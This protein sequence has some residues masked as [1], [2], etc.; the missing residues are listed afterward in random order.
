MIMWRIVRFMALSLVLEF[1][2]P[3][4]I[5]PRIFGV[6]QTT[7]GP[8]CSPSAVPLVSHPTLPCQANANSSSKNK[9]KKKILPMSWA[10]VKALQLFS[11]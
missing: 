3:Q 2:E 7:L 11:N 8:R 5:P 9:E 6:G 1:K 4:I 10:T